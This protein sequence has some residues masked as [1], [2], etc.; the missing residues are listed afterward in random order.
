MNK[1]MDEFLSSCEKLL[2]AIKELTEI[3]QK[4]RQ[5][6]FSHD[7]ESLENL[8][9][10][11]QASIMLVETLENKRVKIQEDM[12]LEGKSFSEIIEA[13]NCEYKEEF[14]SMLFELRDETLKLKELNEI[15]MDIATA[16]LEFIEKA[17]G[18]SA[19]NNIGVYDAY[20]NKNNNNSGLNFREK[21]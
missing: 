21:I 12:G 17:I 18:G 16:E 9:Q 7:L 2:N 11:Q 5:I 8:V 1:V 10:K 6:L 20:G 19:D 3:E 13:I 4:K 15:S 14:T